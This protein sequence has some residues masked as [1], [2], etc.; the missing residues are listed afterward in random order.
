MTSKEELH[1]LVE[2]LPE[3]ESRAAIRFLEYLCELQDPF[4]RALHK[5]RTDDEPLM[6]DEALESESAWKSYREGSDPGEPL[7]SLRKKAR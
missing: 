2:R 3:E 1:Q 6:P 4:M 7:E 5:A